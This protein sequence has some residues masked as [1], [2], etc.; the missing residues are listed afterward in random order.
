[1]KI[2]KLYAKCNSYK[3]VNGKAIERDLKTVEYIVIHYTGNN[4]DTAEN[5]CKYFATS[6]TRSAGAHYFIN[7]DGSV[8]C[9]VKPTWT[10]WAVG[11]S[12]QSSNGG[13]LYGICTNANSISIELCDIA[14]KDASTEQIESCKALIKKIKKKCPNV[15]DVIRH[16]DVNG[17]NCPSRYVKDEKWEK[18]RKAVE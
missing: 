18:F 3:N 13:D 11:G 9:S 8:W 4:G 15:V 5:N 14:S 17:K 2:N 12:K 6:N 7:R 16:F 10:A 1:M